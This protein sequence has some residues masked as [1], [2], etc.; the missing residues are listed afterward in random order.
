MYSR[1]AESGKQQLLTNAEI[2]KLEVKTIHLTQHGL[3]LVV[4]NAPLHH[5]HSLGLLSIFIHSLVLNN[6]P[7]CT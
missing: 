5:I 2:V 4:S 6:R 7:V 3:G 1:V